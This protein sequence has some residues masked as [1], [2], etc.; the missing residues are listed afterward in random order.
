[1]CSLAVV[2]LSGSIALS[3]RG[4]CAFT[5]KA[6]VAQA[7]GAAALVVINDEEG[8]YFWLSCEYE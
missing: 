7:A 5:T 6:E 4:D 1:M 3:M 8:L 2:Q